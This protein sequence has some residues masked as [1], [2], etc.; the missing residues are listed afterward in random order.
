MQMKLEKTQEDKERLIN[1]LV[2]AESVTYLFSIK[3][4]ILLAAV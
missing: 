1:S 2:E 3:C 4:C